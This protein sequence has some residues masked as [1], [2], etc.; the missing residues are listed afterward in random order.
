LLVLGVLCDLL[1]YLFFSILIGSFVL[2]FVPKE[3]RPEIYVSRKVLLISIIGIAILSFMQPLQLILAFYKD[4]GLSKT[5]QSVLFTFEVGKVWI[6]TVVYSIILFIYLIIFDIKRKATYSYVGLLI[7][8]GLVFAVCWGS[9]ASSLAGFSGFL[10]DSFHF[11]AVCIWIGI[12][13]VVGWL[14]T[15]YNNWELFLKWF[16]P[17]AILCVLTTI[18]TGLYLMSLVVEFKDYTNV[19]KITYGQALLLKHILIIP[20]LVFAFINSFLI[21]RRLNRDITFNPIPWIKAE[22]LVVLF[23][24]TATSVL[25]QTSPPQDFEAERNVILSFG[26]NSISLLI[27][28]LFFFSLFILG[29]TKKASAVLSFIFTVVGVLTLYFSL[30]L[31][32]Q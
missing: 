29:F 10:A 5:I 19:W 32:I 20:L 17:I 26:F 13:F 25:G 2:H 30:M 28:S 24:F 22:S 18:G 31:S 14:S 8:V 12:L 27:V 9:H 3:I 6:I 1:L 16:T 23:I 15:D 4:F 7:A 11:L 21:S